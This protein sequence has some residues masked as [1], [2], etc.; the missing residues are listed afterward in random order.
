MFLSSPAS[1]LSVPSPIIASP[2]TEMQYVGQ[3]WTNLLPS[4]RSWWRE[5]YGVDT[6]DLAVWSLLNMCMV[7]AVVHT[8]HPFWVFFSPF[9]LVGFPLCLLICCWFVAVLLSIS[10]ISIAGFVAQK[11]LDS[12]NC[13]VSSFSRIVIF[14]FYVV[15]SEI[16][17]TLLWVVSQLYPG[18]TYISMEK[19]SVLMFC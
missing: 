12:S 7:V 1:W 17:L 3:F 10:E 13:W 6:I 14:C 16:P 19:F 9:V 18:L 11:V 2:V 15:R 5:C 8:I 4:A